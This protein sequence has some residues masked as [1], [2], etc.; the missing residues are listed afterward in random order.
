M[1][2]SIPHSLLYLVTSFLNIVF[3]LHQE[4]SY[5]TSNAERTSF[6]FIDCKTGPYN[7]LSD[8]GSIIISANIWYMLF[9]KI[10]HFLSGKL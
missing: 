3:V 8:V 2:F 10:F 5:S 9:P 6:L 1:Y 4:I 7:V